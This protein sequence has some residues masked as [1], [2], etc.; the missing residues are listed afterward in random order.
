M[1]ACSE[2]SFRNGGSV[3]EGP[4]SVFRA[5]QN[6]RGPG[7]KSRNDWVHQVVKLITR[8]REVRI[9]SLPPR[10]KVLPDNFSYQSPEF[11]LVEGG[12]TKLTSSSRKQRPRQAVPM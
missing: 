4:G 2:G 11:R 12:V 5:F 6:Q 8:Y 1:S 3:R 9:K 7:E 10:P